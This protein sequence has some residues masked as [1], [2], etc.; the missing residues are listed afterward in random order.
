[1]NLKF[2]CDPELW[3]VDKHGKVVPAFGLIPGS[4]EEPHSVDNGA[5]QV[6]G[7]AVEFNIHPVETRE[8]WLH[9]IKSVRGTLLNYV[10]E[11]NP[12]Y[13]LSANPIAHFDPTEFKTYPISARILGCDPD[14]NSKGR[15]NR[16]PSRTLFSKPLRTT[17]GHIHIGFCEDVDRNH[18]EHF[19]KCRALAQRISDR[20]AQPVTEEEIE[21]LKYYGMDGS[22]RPKTYGVEVRSFSNRWLESD[23]SILKMFDDVKRE[24]EEFFSQ[25]A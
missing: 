6:D 3:V 21:R 9:N 24:T 19:E 11:N 16:S 5:I 23:E 20:L 18:P 25:A 2:G 13:E 1:M 4:K 12:E 10:K 22:F 8:E 14:W 15:P 7:L 17:S